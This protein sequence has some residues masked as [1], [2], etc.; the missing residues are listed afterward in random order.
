MNTTA[1]QAN[2]PPR[3]LATVTKYFR[4]YR[5]YFLAGLAVTVLSSGLMMYTPRLV[6]QIIDG[7]EQGRGAGYAGRRVLILVGLTAASGVF[8][9]LMRRTVIWASRYIETDLRGEMFSHLLRLTPS[10]YHGTRT[11]DVMAAMTNDL[12]A[13]RMM[14]GPGVMYTADAAVSLLIGLVMMLTISPSLTLWALLPLLVLPFGVHRIGS[15]IHKRNA[16]IQDHFGVLTAAAQEN[17]AG[18]RVVKAYGQEEREIENFRAVSETYIGLNISLAKVQ[19]IFAPLMRLIAA[20]SYLTVFYM[21][22]LRVINGTET[23]GT[24]ITF[25]GYLALMTWPVIAIGWVVSLYQRGLAS[26]ARVNRLLHTEPEVPEGGGRAAAGPMAGRIECRNLRFS[27][28]GRPVLDG[29]NLMIEPGQTVGL[30]GLTGSGKTTLVNLIARLH[31]VERGMLFIDGVDV[32]DW[33]LRELRRQIGFATQE[34]FLFS[35]S[36]AANIR[37]GRPEAGLAAVQQAARIAALDKDVAE[38]PQGY[39]TMVGERGIT[40]SGGQKQRTAIARAIVVDPRIII[41]D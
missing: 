18:M 10:Y 5:W 36:I 3:Q 21:G 19:G 39:E 13:I 23:L 16:K 31:P 7:L 17:L 15:V 1:T 22:G 8:M 29:V 24:V 33:P 9:F 38:F 4:T 35:D 37:F 11:G 28:N 20:L 40:L 12:E 2:T 30:L 25:F 27:Y 34:P 32:N 14:A 26:L 6:G 41:L